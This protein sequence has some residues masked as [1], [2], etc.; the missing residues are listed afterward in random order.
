MK[1]MEG[2]LEWECG[3]SSLGISLEPFK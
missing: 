3:S 2:I 1:L